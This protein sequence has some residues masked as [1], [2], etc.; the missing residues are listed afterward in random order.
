MVLEQVC[1]WTVG[2]RQDYFKAVLVLCLHMVLVL[3]AVL[4]SIVF[5]DIVQMLFVQPKNGGGQISTSMR[6][7]VTCWCCGMRA[8]VKKKKHSLV[9]NITHSAY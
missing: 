9:L 4:Y 7:L 6:K 3:A 2:V 8:C 5:L 1:L